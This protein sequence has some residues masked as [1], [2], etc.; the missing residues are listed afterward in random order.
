[1]TVRYHRFLADGRAIFSHSWIFVNLPIFV[2]YFLDYI[3]H[4]Q[5][6]LLHWKKHKASGRDLW[7]R[8][9]IKCLQDICCLLTHCALPTCE[10]SPRGIHLGVPVY[11]S[12]FSFLYTF[13][14]YKFFLSWETGYLFLGPGSPR[15]AILKLLVVWPFT[16]FSKQYIDCDVIYHR[17]TVAMKCIQLYQLY[18]HSVLSSWLL[19]SKQPWPSHLETSILY[20]VCYVNIEQA[21]KNIELTLG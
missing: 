11:N 3:L 19:G 8:L 2:L 7:T 10:S 18:T 9:V 1:M 14:I 17:W 13:L 20:I 16:P 21:I 4:H 5:C 12:P 6:F 15:I